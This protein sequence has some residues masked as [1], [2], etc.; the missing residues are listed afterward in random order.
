MGLP[1]DLVFR[2]KGEL[3]R[4]LQ[5]GGTRGQIESVRGFGFRA[6]FFV[7]FV[8]DCHET[9]EKTERTDRAGAERLEL[10]TGGFGIHC[11]TN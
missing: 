2:T 3:A 7:F 6:L 8:H 5:L 10:P 9:S 11:S 4:H 1:Q